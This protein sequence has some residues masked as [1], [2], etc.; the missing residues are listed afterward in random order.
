MST[1]ITDTPIDYSTTVHLSEKGQVT[2]SKELRERLRRRAGAP[3]AVLQIG[4]GLLLLPQQTKFEAVC[5]SIRKILSRTGASEQEILGT[6]PKARQRTF[7]KLYGN[8]V[9]K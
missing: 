9:K 7:E 5:E 4:E 1:Q 8:A 3:L 2:A 6:L